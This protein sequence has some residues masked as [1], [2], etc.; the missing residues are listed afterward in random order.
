MNMIEAVGTCFKKYFKFSGRARRSEF[1][2]WVLF[3]ILATILMG[4]LDL[5]VFPSLAEQDLGP[6]DSFFT[7]GT[8]IPGLAV[9]W[10]RMHDTGR[11]GWWIGGFYLFIIAFLVFVF[12]QF[13]AEVFDDASSMSGSDSLF[14]LL[15]IV[16]MFGWA[17]TILVFFCF[18][19][20]EG[21]NK[22][23]ENPKDE[24]SFVVFD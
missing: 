23:G 9:G 21:H 14:W 22:Y 1:W 3:S 7:L 17:I 15:P 24:G 6:F 10:R 4:I 2:Y 5:I 19:S 18:D 13:G 16:I 11:S 20:Q 8:L 12:V